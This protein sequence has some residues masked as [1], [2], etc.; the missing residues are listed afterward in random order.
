MAEQSHGGKREGSGRKA[1]G[2]SPAV[3]VTVNLPP[4]ILERIDAIAKAENKSRSKVILDI[5]RSELGQK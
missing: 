5:I 4:E 1:L 2:S 3:G